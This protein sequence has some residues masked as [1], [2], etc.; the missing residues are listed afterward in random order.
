MSVK[1][2]QK[3]SRAFSKC[4]YLHYTSVYSGSI[5]WKICW[6]PGR[7]MNAFP[8]AGILGVCK[9]TMGF[10]P[11]V[12]FSFQWFQFSVVIQF[13]FFFPPCR[14]CLFNNIFSSFDAAPSASCFASVKLAISVAA[15]S[16]PA[17]FSLWW[18]SRFN[19]HTGQF[20]AKMNSSRSK[21][22]TKRSKDRKNGF[23]HRERP[24]T[25]QT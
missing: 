14:R 11:S 16:V 8:E 17:W 25:T 19:S 12:H 7:D 4:Y 15:G 10:Q 22:T 9:N 23:F 2:V 5:D 24:K 3:F 6:N 20:R 18:F 1:N 21:T 13:F